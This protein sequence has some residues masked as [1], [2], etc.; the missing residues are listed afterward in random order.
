[1][2]VLKSME[3]RKMDV[4]MDLSVFTSKMERIDSLDNFFESEDIPDH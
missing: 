3:R 2:S 1:M 4:K